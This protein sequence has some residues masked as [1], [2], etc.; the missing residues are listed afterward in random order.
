[1]LYSYFNIKNKHKK[2]LNYIKCNIDSLENKPSVIKKIKK[3]NDCQFFFLITD[4][5]NHLSRDQFIENALELFFT[6]SEI[7]LNTDQYFDLKKNDRLN[8]FKPF[9]EEFVSSNYK[10]EVQSLINYFLETKEYPKETLM[11]KLL[12]LSDNI[13][14]FIFHPAS[15]LSIFINEYLEQKID[16]EKNENYNFLNGISNDL[17]NTIN[18]VVILSERIQEKIDSLS[19][20]N[21]KNENY[22]ID[23]DNNILKK[24]YFSLEKNM[25]IDQNKTSLDQFINVLKLDWNS[26]NSI[27]HLE[28]DNIQFKYFIDCFNQFLK[29]NIQKT[30]IQRAGNIRNK[31]GQIKANSM[32]TTGSNYVI[33]QKDFELIKSIFEKI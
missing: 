27:I 7:L 18:G 14:E 23:T 8:E 15:H 4:L 20:T 10:E 3:L 24:L 29:I 25:F 17:N 6:R 11:T 16:Y 21:I 30:F 28:M 1:M 9:I 13:F 2:T 32:Y 22:L 26:H 31:N 5:M 12:V 19:K 33:K